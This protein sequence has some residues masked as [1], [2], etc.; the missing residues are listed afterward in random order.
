MK[1]LFLEDNPGDAR[2][3]QLMLAETDP[4]RFE[5]DHVKKVA[6]ALERLDSE[7]YDAIISDLGLPDSQG[8]DTLIALQEKASALP[9]IVLTGN[10][11]ESMGVAAV[12]QGAQDYLIKGKITPD[13]LVKSINF[14]IERKHGEQTILEER[15]RAAFFKDLLVHDINNLNH[16]LLFH[17][18][19]LLKDDQVPEPQKAVVSTCRD[20][21]EKIAALITNVHLLSEVDK[22][23]IVLEEIDF[24]TVFN[25]CAEKVKAM[26]SQSKKVEI[27]TDFA[28]SPFYVRGNYLLDTIVTNI[29]INAVKYNTQPVAVIEVKQTLSEDGH[30]HKIEFKDNGIGIKDGDKELI[31]RKSARASKDTSLG[32]GIGLTLVKKVVEGYG[33]KIWVEDRIPGDYSQGSNFVL[34]LPKA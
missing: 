8:L 2:L 13:L 32:L 19:R 27:T 4:S 34:L 29:L 14:S 26:F 33:G 22:G 12:Q 5:I 3:I 21:V 30:F 6:D 11:D 15:N 7:W 9:I 31:F 17:L 28:Q 20:L 23:N 16:G 10:D 25:A 24:N 18:K 1:L